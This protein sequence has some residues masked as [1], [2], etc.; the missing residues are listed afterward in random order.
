MERSDLIQIV[1]LEVQTFLDRLGEKGIKLEL[2]ESAKE[3]II[4]EGYDPNYGARPMR[5]AVE[6]HLEDPL[7][8]MLLRG[9]V[10]SGQIVNVTHAEDEKELTFSPGGTF[11]QADNSSESEPLEEVSTEG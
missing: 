9:D 4:D 11:E 8:E 5:R 6:K 2:D 3:F 7:A 10:E 1:D